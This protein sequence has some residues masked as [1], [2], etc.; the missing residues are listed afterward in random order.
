MRLNTKGAFLWTFLFCV[1]GGAVAQAERYQTERDV[2]YYS[3]AARKADPYLKERCVLDVYYPKGKIEFSTIVWFHGGGLM[4]G[5][6]QVP[7]DLKE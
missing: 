4:K 5:K 1:S 3:D 2:P 6:K 7:K